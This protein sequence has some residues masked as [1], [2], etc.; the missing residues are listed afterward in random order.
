MR[1]NILGTWYETVFDQYKV[2]SVY[3]ERDILAYVSYD[4]KKIHICELES[5]PDFDGTMESAQIGEKHS[6]R[7]EIIHAFLFES[8]LAGE[9]HCSTSWAGNE[10]MID[11]IALQLP[12]IIKVC[13]EA[14]AL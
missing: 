6:L 12:K 8:G 4:A 2:D 5:H 13:E 14:E 9:S 7:H 3:K 1:V 10:E 11:W